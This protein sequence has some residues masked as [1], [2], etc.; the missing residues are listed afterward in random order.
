M[1]IAILSRKSELY[2]TRRL[3]EA[4]LLRGH[5]VKI[6]DTL[7]CYM[8]LNSQKLSI[9]YRGKQ[10]SSYDAVIPRIGSSVSFYG[11]AVVRQ[12]EM[13]GILCANSSLAITRSRDK[14]DALQ[15]LS[16]KNIGLPIT[17]FA[18]SPDDINDLIKRV[19][20]PPLLIKLIE[21]TQGIGVVLA[22]TKKAAESVIQAF[23]GL[24]VNI[25]VQEFIQEAN[26]KD[27]R[28]FVIGDDIVASME[29]T[30]SPGEFRSNVHRGGTTTPV[31]ITAEERKIAV[32]AAKAL[33][34]NIAGVDLL[35]SRR[36]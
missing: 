30:A 29:R 12:F 5:Q 13:M 9:H 8:S 16:R 36:W 32:D 17:G 4:A 6:I 2:S 24:K 15:W 34:L 14:F 3:K 23:L 28:C 20:G 33:G 7:R 18:H 11:T 35:R 25:M 21:G 22:E 10:L 27:L 1:K 31:D 19:G 26:G